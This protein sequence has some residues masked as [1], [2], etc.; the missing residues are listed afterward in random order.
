[1]VGDE[2]P[3]ERDVRNAPDNHANGIDN[4]AAKSC[5]INI[6]GCGSASYAL[7][8]AGIAAAAGLGP[9]VWNGQQVYT[10]SPPS[11]RSAHKCAAPMCSPQHR[12][13]HLAIIFVATCSEH[14]LRSAVL[15][16]PNVAVRSL[17]KGLLA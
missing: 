10:V 13:I 2:W 8:L 6:Q 1:V 7:P 15:R 12:C 11:A 3:V 5:N 9:Y 17:R 4:S 16:S 14:H